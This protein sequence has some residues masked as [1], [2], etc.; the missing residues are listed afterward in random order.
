MKRS[1]TL[2]F[3]L[4]LVISFTVSSCEAIGDIFKAGVWGGIIIAALV[5]GVILWLINKA[6]K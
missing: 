6:K 4:L 5:V 3:A 2:F 1:N